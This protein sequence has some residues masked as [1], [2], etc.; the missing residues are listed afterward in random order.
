MKLKY[1]VPLLFVL[2]VCSCSKDSSTEE[3][4][5][6]IENIS[7]SEVDSVKFVMNTDQFNRVEVILD[8]VRLSSRGY[9]LRNEKVLDSR[10]NNQL[11]MMYRDDENPGAS[12]EKDIRRLVMYN[13]FVHLELKRTQEGK[14]DFTS[15]CNDLGKSI[16]GKIRFSSDDIIKDIPFE[17]T[18]TSDLFT[19]YEFVELKYTDAVKTDCRV[20]TVEILS[21]NLMSCTG[22]QSVYAF[23]NDYCKMNIRIDWDDDLLIDDSKK[24][25]DI[26]YPSLRDIS[27]DNIE[28]DFY[29]DKIPFSVYNVAINAPESGMIDGKSANVVCEETLL[30]PCY[31][32]AWLEVKY[33][34]M[35]VPVEITIAERKSRELRLVKTMLKVEQPYD[36]KVWFDR[37]EGR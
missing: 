11:L 26:N 22:W 28:G 33:A 2:S 17:I 31:C 5:G 19:Y 20:D 14:F 36:F 35:T 16:I 3:P 12:V 32:T 24:Y 7:L 23:P 30:A 37:S 13:E 21:G 27:E 1:L 8:N 15:I 34:I 6:T 29:G 25:P 18:S 9:N 10:G 4:Y